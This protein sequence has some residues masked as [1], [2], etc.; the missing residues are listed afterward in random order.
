MKSSKTKF[1]L[2]ISL[3][4]KFQI[5]FIFIFWLGNN[6]DIELQTRF[7]KRI[8]GVLCA[9]RR[10]DLRVL[11]HGATAATATHV[12]LVTVRWIIHSPTS[13]KD[14]YLFILNIVMDDDIYRV[15]VS[16]FEWV[17]SSWLC[18]TW[19]STKLFYFFTSFSHAR[20]RKKKKRS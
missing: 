1:Q 9:V 15:N 2:W 6:K 11:R 5:I 16:V 4:K 18:S 19:R 7:S 13:Q 10:I 14:I 8:S 3:H 12:S 17:R 20:I